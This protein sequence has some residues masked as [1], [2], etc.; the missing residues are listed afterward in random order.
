MF[1]LTDK[2]ITVSTRN[3]QWLDYPPTPFNKLSVKI[4]RANAIDPFQYPEL[5]NI[6]ESSV[7]VSKS[8]Q[9][10]KFVILS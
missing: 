3:I 10:S 9:I 8:S 1:V 6:N 5:L 4:S 2:A 7:T